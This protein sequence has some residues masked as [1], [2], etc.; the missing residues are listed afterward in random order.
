MTDLAE[1]L[2][3][4]EHTIR[5]HEAEIR[6]LRIESADK[7]D[8]I[9][10]LY[11]TLEHQARQETEHT[12]RLEAEIGRLKANAIA[13]GERIRELDEATEMWRGQFRQSFDP[14]Q[15]DLPPTAAETN[16]MANE[17]RE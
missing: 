12:A 15:Y 8:R 17:E 2:S 6:R 10:G 11:E 14:G 5:L 13:Q 16:A 7:S 4:A 3:I 9:R 1:Q